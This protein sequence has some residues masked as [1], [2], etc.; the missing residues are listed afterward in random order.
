ML[1]GGYGL[2]LKQEHLA[3][4]GATTLIPSDRWPAA[5]STND[6]DLLLRPEIVTRVEHMGSI[7]DALDRLGFQ[8]IET[9]K[10][11][12]FVKELGGSRS[13]KIDLLAGPLGEHDDPKYGKIDSRRIKPQPGVGLHAHRTDEAIAYD[14]DP[15][16]VP[17]A[18]T[19]SDGQR[20]TSEVSIPQAFS[21][22]M[23]KLFAFRDRKD[24]A[25]KEFAQH[26]AL[27]MYRIIAMLTE[28]E[29][30]TVRDLSARYRE[31]PFVREAGAIVS[32]FFAGPD[33]LGVLRMREHPLSLEKLDVRQFV[34]VL[35]EIFPE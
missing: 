4:T 20:A 18:G 3:S 30:R 35:R 26:H 28:T 27:D 13:V 24:D 32:S 19:R 34:M 22:A 2:F 8:P 33:A 17:F 9:A 7:R 15:I 6:I 21:Y 5:R 10:F 29:D 25:E 31:N 23:M 12:Q 16:S 14:I 1:G 11:Y